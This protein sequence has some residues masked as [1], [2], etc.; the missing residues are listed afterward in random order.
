MLIGSVVFFVVTKVAVVAAV[1]LM[2]VVTHCMSEEMWN[3]LVC[4][5]RQVTWE[6]IGKWLVFIYVRSLQFPMGEGF[7]LVVAVLGCHGVVLPSE[8]CV[9]SDALLG[10]AKLEALHGSAS[11]GL[12]STLSAAF[13]TRVQ[14]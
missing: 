1:V 12:M 5:G 7:S 10:A 3:V 2:V 8:W 4:K 11:A 6:G 9:I 14:E 13:L